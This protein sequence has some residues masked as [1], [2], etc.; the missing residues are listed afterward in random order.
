MAGLETVKQMTERHRAERTML[1]VDAVEAAG[2]VEAASDLI[3]TD[4]GIIY[5]ELKLAGKTAGELTR[6]PISL[7]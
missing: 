1:F 7:G 4:R 2:S 6:R 5:R 3:Q